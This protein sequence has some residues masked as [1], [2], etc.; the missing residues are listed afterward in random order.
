MTL[1][2]DYGMAYLVAD[3]ILSEKYIM[4]VGPFTALGEKVNINPPLYYYLI[5]FLYLIL[6]SD[7][8]VS[9]FFALIGILSV[10]L[11]Y[12]LGK[13]IDSPK[14]G[15]LS[16]L[17]YA[18]SF[19]MITYDRNIWEPYRLPFLIISSLLTL[20]LSQKKQSLIYLM[21]SA[22]FYVLSFLYITTLILLP[23]YLFYFLLYIKKIGQKLDIILGF[24]FILLLILFLYIPVLFYET[25]HQFQTL[26]YIRNN[27]SFF[28]K[29]NPVNALNSLLIHI[30][31]FFDSIYQSA[32][33][34]D[35]FLFIFFILVLIYLLIFKK[36]PVHPTNKIVII[37]IMFFSALAITV[38]YNSNKELYSWRLAPLFPLYFL[39][40]AYLISKFQR[41]LRQNIRIDITAIFFIFTFI[42]FKYLLDNY[43]HFSPLHI[44]NINFRYENFFKVGEYILNN[45]KD[46]KFK[47]YA[48]AADNNDRGHVIP[49]YYSILKLSGKNITSFN[50][51]GNWANPTVNIDRGWLYLICS[52]NI[53]SHTECW[54][55]FMLLSQNKNLNYVEKK[56]IGYDFVYKIF[57]P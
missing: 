24:S 52:N 15:L 32:N 48:I 36:K 39:L 57:V 47:I 22:F 42:A 33:Y 30:T 41:I 10:F 13:E 4:L 9:L 8:G 3:R 56:Q 7:L 18:S 49:Y 12:L 26:N 55:K 2:A 27:H 37:A 1:N 31:L 20:F 29:W 54:Y 34:Y 28:F 44:K 50:E 53:L 6:Q 14:T 35:Y 51:S 5:T 19:M 17:F 40:F 46:D 25:Q 11:I 16:A 38:I 45:A 21:L 43:R 23:A